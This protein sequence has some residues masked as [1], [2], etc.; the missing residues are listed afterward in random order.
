MT[1]IIISTNDFNKKLFASLCED[2]E[3]ADNCCLISGE[4][5]DDD[6]V[7]LA[8]GHKFNYKSIYHEFVNQKAYSKL[9]VCNLKK[10]QVKCPYCRNIQTGILPP[11]ADYPEYDGVNWPIS[12]VAKNNKCQVILKSG[13]NKGNVCGRACSGKY[14][15]IHMRKKATNANCIT[16]TAIIKNGKRKGEV[17]GARC[18]TTNPHPPFLCGRHFRNKK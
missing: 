6:P 15:T 14:C 11:K 13:K 17:C 18:K 1:N 12:K 4:L 5:L 9:E 16:C 3:D 8:C 7:I 10:Y 2:E